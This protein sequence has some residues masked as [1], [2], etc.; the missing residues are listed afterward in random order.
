MEKTSRRLN[1]SLYVIGSGGDGVG[2]D[3]KANDKEIK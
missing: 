1:S 2:S 3:K